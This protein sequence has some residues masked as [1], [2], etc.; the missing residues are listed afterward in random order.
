MRKTKDQIIELREKC[1]NTY[2]FTGV[3]SF[4]GSRIA[5][6]LLKQGHYLIFLLRGKEGETVDE[7]VEKMLKVCGYENQESADYIALESQLDAPNLGLKDTDY[8]YLL[9]SVNEIFHCAA[10]TDMEEENRVSVM[11]FNLQGT[12]NLVDLAIAGKCFYFHYMSTAYSIGDIKGKCYEQMYPEGKYF[13]PYEESKFL[14]ESDIINRCKANG[15]R[16]H[17][18]KPSIVYGD[19]ET[20]KAIRFNAFYYFIRT[21]K[22]LLNIYEK[23]LNKG[24]KRSAK[25]GVKRLDDG[26][27]YFPLRIEIANGSR[28]NI[29]PVDYLVKGTLK[30]LQLS[31]DSEIYNMVDQTGHK[32]QDVLDFT[33]KFFNVDGIKAVEEEEY[34]ADSRNTIEELFHNYMDIYHPYFHDMRIFDDTKARKLFEPFNIECPHMDQEIFDR[35]VAFAID[36]Q[37]GK[38]VY[39]DIEANKGEFVKA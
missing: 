29:I 33:C 34:P 8:Q 36:V 22:Y 28:F 37:W 1:K 23:D 17:I 5:T 18:I 13:N 39:K 19:S 32:L 21:V 12:K 31:L 3:T 11:R 35:C 4:L 15:I 20:G 30:I 24:G 14:A 38:T 16:T 9:S 27:L 25:I 2:L 10:N 26:R 7:R 6:E